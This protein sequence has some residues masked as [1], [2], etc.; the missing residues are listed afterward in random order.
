MK[1]KNSRGKKNR[2]HPIQFIILTILVVIMSIFIWRENQ[3]MIICLDAG[4]GGR[5]VRLCGKQW[6]TL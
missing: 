6:E 2:A 3:K 1:R 4:H 5:D